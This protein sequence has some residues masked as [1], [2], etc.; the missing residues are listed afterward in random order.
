MRSSPTGRL[1]DS[2]CKHVS[3][4][5]STGPPQHATPSGLWQQPRRITGKCSSILQLS[6]SCSSSR[7][8]ASPR[9]AA[10]ACV[11]GALRMSDRPC[12]HVVAVAPP[13]P[14]VVKT[15]RAGRRE[16]CS[17]SQQCPELLASQLA[18]L[19]RQQARL[20]Q[21]WG[22]LGDCAEHPG[23]AASAQWLKRQQTAYRFLHSAVAAGH[24]DDTL[25]HVAACSA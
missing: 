19:W 23:A 21:Q 1:I 16:S 15:T 8:T 17:S 14:P 4:A 13:P 24:F 7:D 12:A 5:R 18:S 6:P 10:R 3:A 20:R 9:P 25:G 11:F 22:W 2:G